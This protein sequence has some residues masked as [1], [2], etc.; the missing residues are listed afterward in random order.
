MKKLGIISL[1]FT[2][3]LG[4]IYLFPSGSFAET[5]ETTLVSEDEEIYLYDNETEDVVLTEIPNNSHVVVLEN[6]HDEF[7]L[8]NYTDSNE[9]TY[10]GYVKKRYIATEEMEEDS[11]D[12]EAVESEV[13]SE[14][15][16]PEQEVADQTTNEVNEE[17]EMPNEM[18]EEDLIE[19]GIEED[20]VIEE[21]VQEENEDL[22]KDQPVDKVDVDKSNQISK[23]QTLAVKNQKSFRGIANKSP[24]NIRTS[25]STKSK[26]LTTFPVGT[27]LNYKSYNDHWY[28]ISVSVNGKNRVGYIHKKHVENAIGSPSTLRGVALNSPTNIRSRASTK[29][30]VVSTLPI[31]SVITYKEF[32]A[33]W[34]EATVKVN[35]KNVTGYIHK[36]HVENAINKQESLRGV[37]LNSPT[38]V[39]QRASTKSNVVKSLP[40]GSVIE[41]KTFSAYWYEVIEGKNILGYIHKNHVENAV[42]NQKKFFGMAL[43]SPTNIRSRASTKANIIASFDEE[44]IEEIRSFTTYWYEVQI[45]VNGKKVNGYVHRNHVQNMEGKTLRGVASKST[46]II[47]TEPSTKSKRLTTYSAGSILEYQIHNA[48]WYK[49]RVNVNGK[50]QTGYI[51]KKHT[52]NAKVNQETLRGVALNSPTNIRSAASTKSSVA[53]KKSIGTIFNYRT[54][55]THWYEVI[56]GNIVGYVHKKHVENAAKKQT[57]SQGVALKQP[58]YLRTT[59]S[60]KSTALTTFS[61]GTVISYKNFNTHWNEVTV[62]LNGKNVTGFIHKKHVGNP[63]VVYIDAGHGGSDPGAVGNGLREKDIT[64]DISHSVRAKLEA[65][66]YIVVMSRSGDTYP[67]LSDRTSQANGIKADIF[68]SIHVNSGGGTGIET[69]MMSNGPESAKSKTLADNLQAEMVGQTKANNR[70][71]KD[72]NLHVNRESNMPSAL[73]EVGFIDNKTEASKLAQKSYKEKLATGIANGIKKYFKIF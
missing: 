71:V 52:E 46:T 21:T 68:V 36:K 23:A 25:P 7:A 22:E 38:N 64:L 37:A 17:M 24:T 6:D 28:E 12:G 19:E 60:T 59:P 56:D 35:G 50:V 44:S 45:T 14:E 47:R 33:H 1:V 43:K 49:V 65:A 63:K 39:R 42:A 34:Y 62:N 13:E 15:Q 16:L 29:S 58:T 53:F 8:I 5:Q 57:T 69:W 48:H 30:S 31:G 40:I 67:S 26:V 55:T 51:H 3:A 73:V 2:L 32:S 4:Y 20:S 18:V 41:Y 70:G 72:G 66:G 61:Q 11:I 10:E 9:Q 27:V 54:F